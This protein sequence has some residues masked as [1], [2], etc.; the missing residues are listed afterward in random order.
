MAAPNAE[1]ADVPINPGSTIG[2][3]NKD[4]IIAPETDNDAPTKMHKKVLGNRIW[5]NSPS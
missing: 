4:C 2:L 3:R 1:P 5:K